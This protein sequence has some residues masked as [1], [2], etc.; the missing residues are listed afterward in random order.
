MLEQTTGGGGRG[1][2]FLGFWP[3]G[4][5][6]SLSLFLLTGNL[7]LDM[8][9]TWRFKK[10]KRKTPNSFTEA[11]GGK[12]SSIEHIYFS[13]HLL[14][15]QR[16]GGCKCGS[17]FRLALSLN[18]AAAPCCDSDRG[19]RLFYQQGRDC[20]G[21]GRDLIFSRRLFKIATRKRERRRHETRS[22]VSVGVTTEEGPAWCE[23]P[24]AFA[25]V[26]SLEIRKVY[27]LVL[28]TK[29]DEGH[30]KRRK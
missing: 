18:S 15:S 12:S 10:N 6:R 23:F 7:K 8:F 20:L 29:E 1:R 14:S 21:K 26:N 4:K 2:I 30:N 13:V 3:E 11:S 22:V 5:E 24:F 28:T 17:A 16:G 9:C 19:G 27:S 25:S